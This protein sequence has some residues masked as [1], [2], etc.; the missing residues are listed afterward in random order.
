MSHPHSGVRLRN[1]L[2]RL[3]GGILG[4]LAVLGVMALGLFAFIALVA[5]GAIWLLINTLR[6]KRTP[7][8]RARATSAPSGVIDGE[9]TVVRGADPK[10][11]SQHAVTREIH[12]RAG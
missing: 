12:P 7:V 3:I 10:V 8:L 11:D 5:V 2:A 6:G 1:P 9:F 4:L